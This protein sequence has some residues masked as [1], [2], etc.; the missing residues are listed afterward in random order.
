MNYPYLWNIWR[1][2]WVQYN[3][4]VSQPMARNVG[5]AMGTGAT[6][7]LLDPY[8]RPTP[9]SERYRTTIDFDSLHK[10]ET[11]LQ[12]PDTV[13][14]DIATRAPLPEEHQVDRVYVT[15]TLG[16]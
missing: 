15:G 4:S 13:A 5:E 2:D 10:I 9:A 16:A 11:T 1:F 14:L 12:E 7:H 3:A 8:G 6:Y